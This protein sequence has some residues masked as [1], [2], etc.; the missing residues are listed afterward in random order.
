MSSRKLLDKV[1]KW[2][3]F[4]G[5]TLARTSVAPTASMSKGFYFDGRRE[6]EV[7][8]HCVQLLALRGLALQETVKERERGGLASEPG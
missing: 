8:W 3:P 4:T 1:A 2:L 7:D 5:A 6:Q